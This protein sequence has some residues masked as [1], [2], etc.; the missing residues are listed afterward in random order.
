MLTPVCAAGSGMVAILHWSCRL[1]GGRV[2]PWGHTLEDAAHAG[3]DGG[4]DSAGG[5]ACRWLANVLGLQHGSAIRLQQHASLQ[6]GVRAC[7]A[8]HRISRQN[9]RP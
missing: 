2:A 3:R 8:L 4:S 7:T 1:G 5:S 6:P 9:C